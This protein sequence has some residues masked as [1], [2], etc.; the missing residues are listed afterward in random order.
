MAISAAD[1]ACRRCFFI[2]SRKNLVEKLNSKFFNS[3]IQTMQNNYATIVNYF[4]NRSTN[5]SAESFNAIG[6][7][8]I[9]DADNDCGY[10]HYWTDVKGD[11]EYIQM[12]TLSLYLKLYEDYVYGNGIGAMLEYDETDGD[13]II[14][15][16]YRDV[17]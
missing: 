4:E 8:F 6:Y 10:I 7:D 14:D 12:V 2:I 9:C 13:G 3:V 11:A 15:V 17:A 5:A 16:V 1:I